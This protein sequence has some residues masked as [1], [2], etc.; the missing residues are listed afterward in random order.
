MLERI[1]R[2][3]VAEVAE[4]KISLNIDEIETPVPRFDIAERLSPPARSMQVIAEVKK[5]SPVKGLLRS[6]EDP[7]VLARAYEENGA[8]AISVISDEKFF[9]GDKNYVR[10][11]AS[12]LEVPVL[13][14]D[15]ILEEIQLYETISL[16]ASLVLLIAAL[17][18]YRSLL[19]LSERSL[20]LGLEP[21]VEIHSLEELDLLKDLPV[22]LVG[23][24]NRNLQDF[25]VDLRT[26]LKLADHL[27]NNW[28]KV[29]ESGIKTREDM[30]MLRNCGYNAVLIGETLVTSTDPGGKLK[31]LLNYE[32]E[33]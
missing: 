2:T 17:H 6:F 23:V 16:G 24:N 18:D 31:E 27:D 9:Q 19:R 8:A 12:A 15:F 13:R 11:V 4:L 3:K 20:L 29:S 21:L 25:Q 1:L 26:S 14:K 33:L 28:I 10:S 30:R 32:E 7:V 5:A 22:R